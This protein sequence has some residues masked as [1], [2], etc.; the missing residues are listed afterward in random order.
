M[1][2]FIPDEET[3]SYNSTI[4]LFNKLGKL[5]SLSPEQRESLKEYEEKKEKLLILL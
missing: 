2:F 3:I 5:K 1:S 4:D